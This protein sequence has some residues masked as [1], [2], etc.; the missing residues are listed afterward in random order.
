MN[1][2]KQ[3]KD[4]TKNQNH[5]ARQMQV[6][7]EIMSRLTERRDADP[8]DMQLIFDELA[9]AACEGLGVT[10]ASIW[11]YSDD[12]HKL[13]C[14]GAFDLSDGLHD[15]F[16]EIQI[17]DCPNYFNAVESGGIILSQ[18]VETDAKSR[19]LVAAE[20]IPK[21]TQSI[22]HLPIWL[23]DERIGCLCCEQVGE[24]YHWAKTDQSFVQSVT[25][26][27]AMAMANCRRNKTE[28]LLKESELR[29]ELA[30]N[31]SSDGLWDW[32]LISNKM[33]RSSQFNKLLGYQDDELCEEVDFLESFLHP[34]DK[35]RARVALAA[36]LKD[37]NIDY[38][39]ELRFRLKTG[40]YRWFRCRGSSLR[41]ENGKPYRVSGSITDIDDFKYVQRSLN[42]FKNTLGEV[43]ENIFMFDPDTL[44]YF[45]V[46]KSSICDWGYAES[47]LLGMSP[48]DIEF[49]EDEEEFKSSLNKIKSS[50]S[51]SLNYETVYIRK[52]GGKVDVEVNLKYIAPENARPRFVGIVRDISQ[53]KLSD[54]ENYIQR[55]MLENISEVQDA[56]ISSETRTP[57]Y[58]KLL[59][60][61]LDIT[62]S[63][64]GLFGE[65]VCHENNSSFI[66]CR[67][68]AGVSQDFEMQNSC[69]DKND[70]CRSFDTL[71][72]AVVESGHSVIENDVENNMI[73]AGFPCVCP[74]LETYMGIPLKLGDRLVGLIGI[75]NRKEGYN[76]EI[77][78]QL[79]PL[80]STCA[81]L[82]NAERA[83]ILRNSMEI[84]LV[85]AKEEAER[86]NLT[87]SEFLSSMSHE[88]RTP[89][90][91]IMG[92]SQML[93]ID[94]QLTEKQK[95][96][97]S[98]IYS[99]GS[100]LLEL[101]NDVLDLARIESNHIDLSTEAVPLDGLVKECIRF[102]KPMADKRDI[103]LILNNDSAGNASTKD[104]WVLADNTRFKQVLLNLLSNAI[105]YNKEAGSVT[106]S[107]EAGQDGMH[108]VSIEDNGRGIAPENMNQLFQPFNRLDEHQGETEG[109]GIG[110]VITRKLIELMGGSIQVE[111]EY[112]QGS[113]FII[114]IPVAE[115][116]A[117]RCIQSYET[118][119]SDSDESCREC[120]ILVAEDNLINQE[121]ITLQLNSLGY[122]SAVVNNGNEAFVE[123]QENDYNVLLTD[124]HMPGMGGHELTRAI[125]RSK[126]DRIKNITIIAIT[127]NAANN[128]AENCLAS[129]MNDYLSKPID[130][131][132]LKGKL[133]R[134]LAIAE[135]KVV[136]MESNKSAKEGLPDCKSDSVIDMSE[137]VRYIGEDV[138]KHKH[139]FSLF[140]KTTPE[141]IDALHVAFSEQSLGDVEFHS[142]KIKSSA[143]TLG[144][145]SLSLLC[146]Q[147]ELA[148]EN[149]KWGAIEEGMS[150]LDA[151]VSAVDSSI[152]AY[153]NAFDGLA[154][155]EYLSVR[156]NSRSQ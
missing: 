91:A 4:L 46:N 146:Q 126:N 118:N 105:K 110:L 93:K 65:I 124:I 141:S 131:N 70:Q 10:R 68:I 14:A 106:V 76:E 32:D 120:R 81:N 17:S 60:V 49:D 52:N 26:H 107:C 33:Y 96:H 142:H 53:R 39:D 5:V 156:K 144:L 25:H 104:V 48:L 95:R 21:N 56:F 119:Q 79:Q 8:C 82:L 125:R 69:M 129:G 100:L 12:C 2:F 55:T 123:L 63:E 57:D 35:R 9:Q 43:T 40:K 137:L 61:I 27:V 47:E 74:A 16:D 1:F 20:I 155:Q 13:L 116:E 101:I 62:E 122:T 136:E 99:A 77:T 149:A 11:L 92:F 109:T 130:R 73:T 111:S 103:D 97:S 31:G 59:N 153:L 139:F 147:L 34:D 75:A 113:K 127:A 66:K 50:K 72:G 134:W 87:K 89:L 42:R 54:I 83:E 115:V 7:H 38:E 86:A 19:E 84:D 36:H 145:T 121:L 152:H 140:L 44:K 28:Q 154:D 24:A 29:Y 85:K 102:I 150:K 94:S 30:V 108:R 6:Q 18:G 132:D 71:L 98:V 23:D 64:F 135:E 51:S 37:K 3:Q 117:S 58:E 67:Y 133:N 15:I 151:T 114:D 148:A 78:R 143:H 88:L 45:Y 128:E 90:N 80:L 138:A 112:G 41:D 22:L